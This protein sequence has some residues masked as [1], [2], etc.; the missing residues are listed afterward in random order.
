MP[1]PEIKPY[2]AYSESQI[3]VAG[4]YSDEKEKLLSLS[5][6]L[7]QAPEEQF[8]LQKG[9]LNIYRFE[10]VIFGVYPHLAVHR[11]RG[12]SGKDVFQNYDPM[13]KYGAGAQ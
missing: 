2:V 5:N 4:E 10:E 9:A 3:L 1:V 6:I 13:Q 12:T 11:R 8:I 7:H